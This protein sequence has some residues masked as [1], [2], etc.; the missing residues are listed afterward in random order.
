MQSKRIRIIV[1]VLT[2][3]FVALMSGWPIAKTR[4]SNK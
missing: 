1:G 4:A 2:V 3:C